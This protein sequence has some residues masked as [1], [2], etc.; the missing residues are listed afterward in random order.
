LVGEV[1]WPSAGRMRDGALPS[2]S[3][4]ARAIH[5]I[6]DVAKRDRF[7]VNVI[8]AFDQPWKENQEGTVGGHWGF[9]DGATREFKFRWGQAVSDHPAWPLR[10]GEGVALASLIFAAA[11]ATRRRN[12][13][14]DRRDR[15]AWPAVAAIALVSGTSIGWANENVPIESLGPGGW[16]RSIA[17]AGLAVAAPIAC[18]ASVIRQVSIPGF[19]RVLGGRDDRPSDPLVLALGAL[20]VALTVI[21][22]Q[23]AME[24]V[25]DPRY[26]DFPFAPLGGAAVPFLIVSW[27][28]E[29]SGGRRGMAETVAGAVL[30]GS[31]IYIALNE[32]FENWQAMWFCAG[33]A[34][35]AITLSRSRDAR[36]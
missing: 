13:K 16:L 9:L 7:R 28:G 18:A 24:L 10:A 8:E 26:R 12:P 36:S 1:G 31:A 27:T 34:M 23:V 33:C 25:F 6:L 5:D 11:L 21:A 29:R 17:M 2:P 32:G 22:V 35:I 30:A 4:Q 3:N 15:Q 19:W 20:F 14:P